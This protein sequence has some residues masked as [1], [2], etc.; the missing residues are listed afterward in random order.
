M[1]GQSHL[2]DKISRP[3]HIAINQRFS[4]KYHLPALDKIETAAYIQHRLKI[5][6]CTQSI[7]SAQ[8]LEAIFQNSAGVPRLIDNLAI[9]A[10]TLAAMK[11]ISSITEEEVF[12]ASKEL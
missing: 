2:R 11:N 7:F 12:S 10:I 6:G 5:A 1:I 9:K 4:L 3:I 8:A